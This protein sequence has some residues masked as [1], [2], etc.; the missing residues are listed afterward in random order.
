MAQ[1]LLASKSDP[2]EQ[3]MS[4]ESNMCLLSDCFTSK[5]CAT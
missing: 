1:K 3:G 2:I 4:V 5:I